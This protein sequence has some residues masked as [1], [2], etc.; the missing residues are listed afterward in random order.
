MTSRTQKTLKKLILAGTAIALV[1]NGAAFAQEK[2]DFDIEAQ[3]LG[4]ALNEFGIQSGKEV[5]YLEADIDGKRSKGVEGRYSADEA[6]NL[7]LNST[8]IPHSDN[9]AGT[10]LIGEAYIQRASLG[11]ERTPA[12]FR[13]AQVAQGST[14]QI[15]DRQNDQDDAVVRQ[16]V[17]VVTGTSIRGATPD[18][19]PLDVFLRSDIESLGVTSI[20][21]FT[22]R[23]PQ[24]FQRLNAV[25]IG[26]NDRDNLDGV[27]AID[28]RGLGLGSTLILL[29]G[30]RFAPASSGTTPDVSLIPLAALE[31]V[32]VL[33]DG[34][35]SIYGAD[36][37]GGVVNF[38]LREDFEGAESSV[39]YSFAPEG[40]YD[41]FQAD[42]TFGLN[43]GTGNLLAS[44][45]FYEASSLLAG[46]RSFS[47]EAE[48]FLT[49]TPDDERHNFLLVGKQEVNERLELFADF[50]YSNREVSSVLGQFGSSQFNDI[51][52][53]SDQVFVNAGVRYSL[54]DNL[55]SEFIVSYSE[56]SAD[57]ARDLIDRR[58]NSVLIE[59]N[60][61]SNNLDLTAKV[62]GVLMNISDRQVLFALGGGFMREEFQTTDRA[63]QNRETRY[64]FGEVIVPL[65][66][67]NNSLPLV[68]RLELNVSA[69]YTST[70]DFGDTLD[71]KFGVVYEPFDGLRLRG[72]YSTSFRAPELNDLEPFPGALTLVNPSAFGFPD[73]FSDDG[74]TVYLFVQT[75]GNAN[76]EPEEA[77]A[78]TAGFDFS[79][80]FVEGLTISGTYFN[81]DYT[82]RIGI[83]DRTGGGALADPSAVPDL[84]I[85]EF[86][87][88]DISSITEGVV[89]RL[90]LT[91]SGADLEDP[92]SL[93]GVA[94]II[95]DN[96]IRNLAVAQTDGVDLSIDYKRQVGA[97]F[98]LS[99][100]LA[101]TYVFDFVT[102]TS[103]SA[104]DLVVLDTVSNP[105]NLRGRGYVGVSSDQLSS[106]LNL[107]YVDDYQ[108][109]FSLGE[110]AVDSW[111]TVDWSSS[112]RFGRT[113]PSVLRGVTL[114]A[115]I[116][117]LFD[118]DPPFV[119]LGSGGRGIGIP[120]G[121]DSTNANPLGR[122]LSFRLA[123]SW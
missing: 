23:L 36:A 50:L 90:D 52:S 121:F 24:N 20:D 55:N 33:T 74:S 30:R 17:I 42:Q 106:Q 22:A 78:F 12:P 88:D 118:T 68:D 13:V 31:R 85:T 98:T 18:S 112:Y 38:L 19:S 71:P 103:P 35:S 67:Q 1:T 3:E 40:S 54:T 77:E 89:N 84:F 109:P 72:T 110:T 59:D 9:G 43:W 27:N 21:Q 117:N 113:S 25:G 8:G 96:R 114:S 93:A 56:H 5:Y 116:Q 104:P 101:L 60:T 11:E 16:D 119:D 49:L 48:P 82:D 107:N 108:N 95:V 44:Y 120:V 76:L 86:D 61:S 34:A 45:S 10:I 57:T 70:S 6:I 47:A 105:V 51:N 46:E 32:E 69:R 29:N 53:E 81:V 94:T 62:D 92:A 15:A 115:N 79:P 37:V 123:K 28:L 122:V 80:S 39:N 41:I 91:G 58:G 14:D 63:D 83:P 64:A 26:T 65:V 99:S 102:R 111:V 73:P 4:D 87:A 97:D 2:I 7:L 100:G 75:S 66:D